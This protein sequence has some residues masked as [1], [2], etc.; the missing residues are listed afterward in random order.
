MAVERFDDLL[1]WQKARA[2]TR[3]VYDMSR[4]EPVC[5]DFR[6]ASQIQ[7]ASVSVMSNVAEGFEWRRPRQFRKFL[8][9]AKSSCAE[10]RSLLYVALDN[11]YVTN[12]EFKR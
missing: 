8:G 1:A 11:G 4:R 6:F 3:H 12:D 10:V 2:L 7:G 9:T 5:R